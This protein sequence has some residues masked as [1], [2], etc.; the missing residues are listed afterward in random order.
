MVS[1]R[2]LAAVEGGFL[3]R[4]HGIVVDDA[5][6][7]HSFLNGLQ[8]PDLSEF[9]ADFEMLEDSG[10]LALPV[11]R[12]MGNWFKPLKHV[13]NVWQLMSTSH[14]LLGF[15]HGGLLILTNGFYK[16]GGSTPLSEIEICAKLQAKFKAS[17]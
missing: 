1:S 2:P 15:R 9:Y 7:V 5:E 3:E 17:T 16:A 10:I 4:I 14:R 12:R 6:P 13:S 8:E 11:W